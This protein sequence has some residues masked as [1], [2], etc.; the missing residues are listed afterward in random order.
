MA[1]RQRHGSFFDCNG[2][3]N[4][5]HIWQRHVTQKTSGSLAA[6]RVPP[7][8]ALRNWNATHSGSDCNVTCNVEHIQRYTF[9]YSEKLRFS[10]WGTTVRSHTLGAPASTASATKGHSRYPTGI[11]TLPEVFQLGNS[12]LPETSYG[13]SVALPQRHGTYEVSLTGTRVPVCL[14][15]KKISILNLS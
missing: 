2:T 8:G 6:R 13:S 12:T 15:A 4:V 10:L 3:C 1:L 14:K 11:V 9:R 7:S 5:E